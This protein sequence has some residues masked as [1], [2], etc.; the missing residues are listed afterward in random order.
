[1]CVNQASQTFFSLVSFPT[2]THTHTHSLSV[3]CVGAPHSP[4]NQRSRVRRVRRQKCVFVFA[5][6][7]KKKKEKKKSGRM[8]GKRVPHCTLTSRIASCL[9][10]P[11]PS[12]RRILWARGPL[13][14]GMEQQKYSHSLTQS[15]A[16]T[17]TSTPTLG[18]FSRCWNLKLAGKDCTRAIAFWSLEES[19]MHGN[20]VSLNPH[21]Q[22]AHIPSVPPPQL[23]LIVL[24]HATCILRF[25]APVAFCSFHCSRTLRTSSTRVLM[26]FAP[27]SRVFVC[28]RKVE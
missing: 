17:L 16:N 11:P 3:V 4:G 27:F 23:W 22:T 28:Q 1:M 20:I 9:A 25:A 10:P 14:C 26:R 24:S 7:R 5:C 15:H 13:S 12:C 2:R 8:R 18:C 6:E 19:D 21:T